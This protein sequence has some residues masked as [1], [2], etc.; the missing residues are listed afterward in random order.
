MSEWVPIQSG[1]FIVAD[2]IRWKEGVYS[3]RRSRNAKA[4]RLGDRLVT[5]E[6][7]NGPD[8][9]GW[10]RLLVRKCDILTELSIRKPPSI[11]S[12]T[13]IRRAIRTIRRGNPERMLW[14]DESARA[15]VASTFLAGP[16]QDTPEKG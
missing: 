2:V 4:S 12:E 14:G 11:A 16:G 1:G 15:L 13:E 6:V 9:Q 7:L 8:G 10:V 5:A 3:H